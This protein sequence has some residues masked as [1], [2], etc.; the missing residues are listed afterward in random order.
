M[1]TMTYRDL[2][3]KLNEM[4]QEQLDMD[5]TIYVSGVSEYYPV[6]SDYPLVVADPAINDVLDGGQPY[7]VI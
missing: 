6:V 4:S 5:V 1:A 2:N 3:R 7:L